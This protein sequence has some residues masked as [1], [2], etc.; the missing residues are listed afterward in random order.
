M[1]QYRPSKRPPFFPTWLLKQ[2]GCS[3]N[4]DAVLGD[5]VERYQQG[6]TAAWYWKQSLVAVIVSAFNEVR[7]HK[8]LAARAVLVG[9][10]LFWYVLVPPASFIFRGILD[11][12]RE[13]VADSWNSAADTAFSY[14]IIGIFVSSGFAIGMMTGWI[15]SRLHSQRRAPILLLATTI[16]TSFISSNLQ[17]IDSFVFWMAVAALIGG[18][19]FGGL[20]IAGLRTSVKARQS[21]PQQ[22]DGQ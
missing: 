12:Y 20:F 21:R 19:L 16:P 2:L 10:I 7:G 13:F 6:K 14:A 18:I 3:S 15:V 5:L 17:G 9:W 4:N 1:S 8:W 11:N 22:S